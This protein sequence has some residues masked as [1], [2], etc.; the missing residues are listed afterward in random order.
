M[1]KGKRK[2]KKKSTMRLKIETSVAMWMN[3]MNARSSSMLWFVKSR[4][5]GECPTISSNECCDSQTQSSPNKWEKKMSK[6]G[7]SWQKKKRVKIV[8]SHK[9]FFFYYIQAWQK[10]CSFG[11]QEYK[12]FWSWRRCNFCSN[13]LS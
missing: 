11:I 2:K 8:I 1:K 4:P 6:I 13:K 9:D 12:V 10:W 3:W 5:V 7:L